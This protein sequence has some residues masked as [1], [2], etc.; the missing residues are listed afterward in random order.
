MIRIGCGS[1][2]DRDRLDWAEDMAYSGIVDYMGF[3]SL[4]ER[5]MALNQ[6]RKLEDPGA[7]WLRRIDNPAP[8][9]DPRLGEIA[10]R[11]A[12]YV[13]DGGTVIGNFGAANPEAG[14]ELVVDRLR[15]A[16]ATGVKVGVIT[17]DD[18]LAQV[19]DRDLYLPEQ[20][21]NVSEIKDRVLSANAYI[22]ADPVVEALQQGAR[23][24]LGGRLAD[25]SPYVGAICHVNGWALDDWDRVAVATAAGHL[26]ECGTSI[27]GGN[28]ADPPYNEVANWLNLSFPWCEVDDDHIV[29]SKLPGSGGVVNERTTKLQL[30]YEVH[31]PANY[32]TPDVTADYSQAVV[33]EL[34]PDRVAL[35]GI[36]GRPRP[37]KLKVLVGL[38]MGWKVFAEISYGGPGC[39]ER[40]RLAGDIVR[41][42]VA[43]RD[44]D[45]IEWR[46]D[47]IGVNALY[48][49]SLEGGYPA[50]VRIRIA[51]RTKTKAGAEIVLEEAEYLPI[52]G[53]AAGGGRGAVNLQRAIG[54]TP[55]FL[56]REDVPLKVKVHTV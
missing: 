18:V 47:V 24:I 48:G 49:E 20:G 35:S 50:D 13:R 55:A 54:V 33:R 53:P 30:T 41:A 46:T 45:I 15:E 6:L 31:D 3:D 7:G 28:Y 10:T 32:L 34:G 39:V 19:L 37:D 36:S 51:A 2:F 12:P 26:L 40:A 52:S 22:G 4:A 17:G 21:C 25:P 8:G 16:G 1:A 44:A 29:V 23:F 43:S 9:F 38:D 11:L 14:G 42:R 27:T 5:S 56:P